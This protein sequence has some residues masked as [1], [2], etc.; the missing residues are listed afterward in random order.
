MRVTRSRVHGSG[1]LAVI[2]AANGERTKSR[3]QG[4]SEP[5]LDDPQLFYHHPH[6]CQTQSSDGVIS[7]AWGASIGQ[8]SDSEGAALPGIASI[9]TIRL[10]ARRVVALATGAALIAQC[11]PGRPRRRAGAAR[12][13]RR[14]AGARSR[15]PG[16][17][18]GPKTGPAGSR[19]TG[20]ATPSAR[21]RW[22]AFVRGCDRPDLHRSAAAGR[23]GVG[24]YGQPVLRD[25]DGIDGF[26]DAD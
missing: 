19:P 15:D 2:G 21:W 9:P 23:C 10:R 8:S 13:G 17:T 11:G 12:R 4:P 3:D 25:V 24:A 26:T 16:N 20:P 5:P 7:A 18:A 6:R 14:A 22:R 1:Q